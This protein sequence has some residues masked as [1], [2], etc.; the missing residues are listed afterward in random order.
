MAWPKLS[1]FFINE[2][3]VGLPAQEPGTEGVWLLHTP[4]LT[5]CRQK[6]TMVSACLSPGHCVRTH[7]GL[8][9]AVL[10]ALIFSGT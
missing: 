1:R 10:V 4:R 7:S 5:L 9:N 2:M 6:L 8:A 3:W